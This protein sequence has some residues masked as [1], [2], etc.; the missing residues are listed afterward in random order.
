MTRT[1]RSS[2]LCKEGKK[3]EESCIRRRLLS[4]PPL[5]TYLFL[6]PLPC[7]FAQPGPPI[8]SV[9]ITSLQCFS[10]TVTAATAHVTPPPNGLNQNYSIGLGKQARSG[11]AF[12]LLLR[13]RPTAAGGVERSRLSLQH[14]ALVD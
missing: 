3:E 12:Y 13:T 5:V 1:A 11:R 4:L 2:D 6:A 8:T 10:S 7:M 14:M 9:E